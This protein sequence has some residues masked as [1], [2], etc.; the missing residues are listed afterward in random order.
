MGTA[1][2]PHSNRSEA[3]E[4]LTEDKLL[5]DLQH[6]STSQDLLNVIPLAGLSLY[7]S[8]R[9]LPRELSIKNGCRGVEANTAQLIVL[10]VSSE[11]RTDSP[12]N[13]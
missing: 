6:L 4:Y 7:S 10:V 3:H 2:E 8:S 1:V 9:L 5:L 11:S 13:H 12:Y